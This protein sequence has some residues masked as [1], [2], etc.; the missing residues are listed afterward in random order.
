M[1]KEDF[2]IADREAMRTAQISIVRAGLFVGGSCGLL[3]YVALSVASAR[4]VVALPGFLTRGKSRVSGALGVLTGFA[5]FPGASASAVEHL[6]QQ[7]DLPMVQSARA[8]LAKVAPDSYLLSNK[9]NPPA[10]S[11]SSSSS[12]SS[13][14]QSD[15]PPELP[16]VHDLPDLSDLDVHGSRGGVAGSEW[17]GDSHGDDDSTGPRDDH[18][19]V[20][21]SSRSSPFSN[22][23]PLH[24][25]PPQ[26]DQSDGWPQLDRAGS[27]GGGG[28]PSSPAAPAF[29]Y[30]EQEQ[31]DNDYGFRQP[32]PGAPQRPSTTWDEVRR[33]FERERR[34]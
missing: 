11:W 17:H 20:D 32:V 22:R 30:E 31:Y 28:L 23:E 29:H 21:D 19:R 13:M 2:T 6:L 7:P 9:G 14:L 8:S 15:L 24:L 16:D 3:A 27:A 12:S 5:T 26:A 18:R 1:S 33:N 10:P 25:P 34:K 4:A